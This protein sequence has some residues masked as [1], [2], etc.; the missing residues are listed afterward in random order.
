MVDINQ[1]SIIHKSMVKCERQNNYWK[2][3]K[4]K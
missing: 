1:G 4:E 2:N 3:G